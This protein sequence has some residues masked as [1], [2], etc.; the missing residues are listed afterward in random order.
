MGHRKRE[1]FFVFILKLRIQLLFQALKVARRYELDRSERSGV[2][3]SLDRYLTARIFASF[4]FLRPLAIAPL[5]LR[6]LKRKICIKSEAA[7]IDREPLLLF[8]ISSA[9]DF[10]LRFCYFVRFFSLY[11]HCFKYGV[12]LKVDFKDIAYFIS[13]CYT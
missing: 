13:L 4:P 5:C 7:V 9:N 11:I 6:G 2:M 3:Y 12:L 8:C 10:E 1:A